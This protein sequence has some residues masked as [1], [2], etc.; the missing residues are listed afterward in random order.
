[1][2]ETNTKERFIQL[3]SEG[4]SFDKIALELKISKPTL[5]NWSKELQAEIH[6][7]KSIRKDAILEE[8]QIRSENRLM[9]IGQ[10]LNKLEGELGKRDF[11]D[12]LTHK[13][14]EQIEK[15]N[16]QISLVEQSLEFK[17]K[18]CLGYTNAP[19]SI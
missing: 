8:C 2:K 5:I 15:L 12:I 3:R 1:M 6:N 17:D 9:L 14:L 19:W 11:S 18:D 7:L 16:E 10:T 13:L 4:M